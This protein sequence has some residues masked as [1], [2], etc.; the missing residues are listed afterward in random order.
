MIYRRKTYQIDP[1]VLEP[2]NEHFNA[3]LLP[4]QLKYG[5]RLVGRWMTKETDGMIEI[6]AIWEYDSYEAYETIETKVKSDKAHVKRVQQWY[7]KMGGKEKLK[8]LF[9]KIEQDFVEATVPRDK[10]IMGEGGR[11]HEE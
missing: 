9:F 11:K 10:T 1:S 6:F 3:T 4:A 5:A 2:F 8:D 7:Q